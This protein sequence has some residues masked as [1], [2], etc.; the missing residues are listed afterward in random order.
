MSHYPLGKVAVCRGYATAGSDVFD[1][2]IQGRGGHAAQPDMTI[3]PVVIGAQIVSNLQ[4]VASRYV[5]PLDMLVVSVTKL[6]GGTAYNIIPDSVLLAG[7]VRSL[8]NET[9]EKS[10]AMDKKNC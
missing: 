9:R 1:L 4:Q 6:Q 8:N 2:V 3:D 10:A 5:S 7:T